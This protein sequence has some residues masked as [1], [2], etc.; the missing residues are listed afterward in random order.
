M[1]KSKHL[2]EVDHPYYCSESNYYSRE[3]H[4][5]YRS[6]P[7]FLAEEGE[8]DPDYNLVFR[9]DWREGEDWGVGEYTGDPYY[10]YAQLWIFWIGQRKGLFR[11]T[12]TEVCRADE[13]A[14]IEFLKPR[15]T[16]LLRLW[17]PLEPPQAA[18]R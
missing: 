6:W 17:E 5:S 12:C 10:R 14:I 11:T 4:S 1:P 2:W 15:L 16:H 8:S 13:P 3:C 7:E 18:Q 9:F